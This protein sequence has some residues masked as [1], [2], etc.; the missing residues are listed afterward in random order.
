MLWVFVSDPRFCYT[1]GMDPLPFSVRLKGTIAQLKRETSEG[2][3][4]WKDTI[5]RLEATLA[6]VLAEEAGRAGG[7]VLAVQVEV[8]I[9]EDEDDTVD[10]DPS[11][12]TQETA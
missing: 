1:M 10:P 11:E 8:E 5:P 9:E 7:L 12:M 2:L 3:M 6:E 4:D